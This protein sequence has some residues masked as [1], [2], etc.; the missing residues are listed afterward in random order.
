MDTSDTQ[1][2]SHGTETMPVIFH[3]KTGTAFLSEAWTP[4][5]SGQYT[6]TCL[7]LVLFT[8]ILRTLIAFKPL[9]EAAV[10]ER[11]HGK[12]RLSNGEDYGHEETFFAPTP[13][14]VLVRV[15]HA[16]YEAAIAFLGYLPML[17]VMSMNLGYF[18]SVLLEVFVGTLCLGYIA[19]STT[20][21]HCS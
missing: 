15:A 16:A 21:D 17:G 9:L 4:R 3:T 10:S 18:L 8:L 12:S 2:R 14:T 7:A 1:S 19:R 20:F 5:T 11:E 13:E 6:A